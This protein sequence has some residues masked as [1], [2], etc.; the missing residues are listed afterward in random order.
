K[1]HILNHFDHAFLENNY[2]V[3]KKD[4]EIIAGIR[5]NTA[6][7][8][9]RSL[10]GFSGMLIVKLFPYLPVLSRLFNPQKFRF[11][12]FDGIYSK[13]GYEKELFVLMESVCASLK[14]TTGIMWLDSESSLNDRLKGSGNWGIMEKLKE[15]IPA[16]VV[17]AFKNIPQDEQEKASKFPVYIS[18]VDII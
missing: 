14:V 3:L 2:Y 4:N 8:M 9:V 6:H 16:Y 13:A 1:N 15:N 18:A 17:A 10:Q 12:A 11:A 5:T 7:W